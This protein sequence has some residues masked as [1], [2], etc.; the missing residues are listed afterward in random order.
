MNIRYLSKL[1]KFRNTTF[2]KRRYSSP[3]LYTFKL[4]KSYR[5]FCILILKT[6]RTERDVLYKKEQLKPP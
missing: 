4:Y 1:L 3:F 5:R 6:T 2:K